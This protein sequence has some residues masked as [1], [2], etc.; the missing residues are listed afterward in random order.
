MGVGG[1]PLQ[2]SAQRATGHRQLRSGA[3][4]DPHERRRARAFAL[5]DARHL[6]GRDPSPRGRRPHVLG[7]PHRQRRRRGAVRPQARHGPPVLGRVAPRRDL[8]QVE[9]LD[10]HRARRVR[11]GPGPLPGRL[12]PRSGPPPHRRQPGHRGL[13][14]RRVRQHE[15]V[16]HRL[17]RPG[18]GVLRRLDAGRR[19]HPR[20][21]GLRLAPSPH[22]RR[23]RA[24]HKG[25]RV[26]TSRRQD[27]QRRRSQRRPRRGPGLPQA[28]RVH[29]RRH[30][31]GP[32][33]ARP[34]GREGRPAVTR[35]RFVG[36]R[37]E[38]E[39]HDDDDRGRREGQSP[40]GPHPSRA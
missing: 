12:Q 33:A 9:R 31:R 22:R 18:H 25:P 5:A 14:H 32:R 28:R 8:G 17:R 30:R 4:D 6:H 29:R 3:E 2:G 20:E 36:R 19:G 40:R 27:L 35:R 15:G 21:D 34:R 7:L 13:G 39:R 26:P 37:R 11:R 10:G 16:R 24:A 38:V 23:P 1:R